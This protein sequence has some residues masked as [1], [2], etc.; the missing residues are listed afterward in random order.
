MPL[1]TFKR[2]KIWYVRGTVK[3]QEIYESTGHTDRIQAD[4]CRIQRE[5]ELYES[6]GPYTKR[7]T[8]TD[9][10]ILYLKRGGQGL[11]L[12]KVEE[13]LKDYALEDISQAVLDEAA[14]QTYPTQKIA[15]RIR[16]FYVPALAVMNAAA[17]GGLCSYKR[18][19]KPKSQRPPAD[20]CDQDYLARLW[21]ACTAPHLK[22]L[23]IFL[24]YT[25]CR[26]GDCL[27][28]IWG[29][30]DLKE[31]RAF[32]PKTKNKDPRFVELPPVV[33]EALA[34]IRP[35][36]PTY[37]EK[38]FK[39]TAASTVAHMVARACKNAGIPYKR[40]HIIGS[41]TYAT[42]MQM[43]GGVGPLDL[44]RTGRW[45]SLNSVK[46]Y[47]HACAS[48]AARKSHNLP[49]PVQKPVQCNVKD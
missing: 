4:A 2:G 33:V 26:M 27:G 37:N 18:F 15:T 35:D 30:V 22:A 31:G 9:A 29:N 49:V 3:G 42:W 47:N 38:V 12:E 45:K 41:H 21:E 20:Y 6:A 46:I 34:A 8:F 24:P 16:Q 7:A 43:Y 10:A 13:A 44:V 5:R 36:N 32:I 23:M 14:Y 11:Y 39:Y 48:E 19:K 28:L 40:P 17:E 25:G 1:K